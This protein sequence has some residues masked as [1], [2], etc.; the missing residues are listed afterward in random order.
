MWPHRFEDSFLQR[1][2][3]HLQTRPPRRLIDDEKPRA[4]VLVPLCHV[5]GVAS[6]LFTKR[7]ELVGTHKGH[8]SFPGGRRDPG[9]VDEVATALRECEE[10]VGVAPAQVRVLGVF[11]E[12][13]AITKVRVTPVVAYLGDVDVTSLRVSAAEIDAVFALSVEQLLN[14][15]ERAIQTFGTRQAP[16]FN[17]GPYPVWGLTAF[18]LDE[19]LQELSG[20]QQG[21]HQG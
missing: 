6:V 2:S 1:A 17:A 21:T 16:V 7:T 12:A 15:N 13:L 10:E 20:L 5:D 8:V 18:I 4:S 19:L 9:D 11:H 3:H 14:P